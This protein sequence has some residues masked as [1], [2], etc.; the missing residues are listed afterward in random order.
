MNA[1]QAYRQQRT[2]GWSRIDKVLAL[3]ELAIDR[4]EAALAALVANE[5]S[6]ALPL[7][8]RAQLAV[9][10]LSCG[11]DLSQGELPLN[12][13]R[14]YEFVVHGL[15]TAEPALVTAAVNVLRTLRDGF[16]GIRDE[17][18]RIEQD[19]SARGYA[20]AGMVRKTA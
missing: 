5:R 20:L 12:L 11:L 10:G 14:L 4:S 3:F 16:A 9:H 1:V 13:R 19:D 17:A 2:L 7:L 8:A 6:K 18:A 15:S